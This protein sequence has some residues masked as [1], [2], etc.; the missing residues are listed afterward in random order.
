MFFHVNTRNGCVVLT[1]SSVKHS[2][3]PGQVGVRVDAALNF[4][5]GKTHKI[6]LIDSLY[7]KCEKKPATKRDILTET[8]ERGLTVEKHDFP[9]ESGNSIQ[10]NSIQ[11]NRFFQTQLRSK[12][13]H[14][15]KSKVTYI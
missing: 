14:N 9:S 6:I 11:F 5:T 15:R 1:Y 2:F 3:N 4:K 8:W 12:S 10:F 7:D 13:K